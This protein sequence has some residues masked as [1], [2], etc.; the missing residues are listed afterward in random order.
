DRKLPDKAID[1]IDEAGATA[2]LA[3]GG[4]AGSMAEAQKEA[5]EKELRAKAAGQGAKTGAP[6]RIR[7]AGASASANTG[8]GAQPPP[9]PKPVATV[10]VRDIELV[11]A[12]M[13]QIPPKEVST[14]D[15][16][17]LRSLETDL[18]AVIFG[19][20]HAVEEVCAAIKLA[21]AGLRTVE[22]PIG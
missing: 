16:A 19:Q 14:D 15:K 3:H 21:R 17:A 22:K 8:G 18:K 7:P 2:K 1:L 12:R 11:V 9:P 10:E 5:G 20:D 4:V 13:A 6:A